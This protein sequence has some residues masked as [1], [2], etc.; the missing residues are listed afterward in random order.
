QINTQTLVRRSTMRLSTVTCVRLATIAIAM[1]APLASRSA[2]RAE[3]KQHDSQL[4]PTLAYDY[5][6][7]DADDSQAPAATASNSGEPET[8]RERYD[9]GK[10]RIER[11][12]TLDADGNYV[13][14]GEWKM[15]SHAGDVVA[16]G[17]Y[18]MG[19]RIGTWTRWHG[20]QD[21]PELS[22]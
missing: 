9:D 5:N 12:V 22:E 17:H 21:C 13:N 18:D 10:V 11:Q 7:Q 19:K 1:F 2:L 20:R 8:I 16:E 3:P 15:Y 14:H 6:A 4:S